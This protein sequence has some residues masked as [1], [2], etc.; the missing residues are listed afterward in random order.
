MAVTI[1]DV[2]KKANVAPSTVSRVIANS[3]RISEKTKKRVRKIMDELGYHPNVNARSLA[4]QT[5]QAIGLIM[6]SS[7]N[8]SFQN[9]F[10]P[11]VMRGISSY[12]H[13]KDYSLY[14]NTGETE[15]EIFEGVVKMV[16]GKRVDGIVVLYSRMNDLVIQ[17]LTE[18]QFPFVLIGKPHH[19][20]EEITYID[21]DNYMAG[22]EVTEY[23]ISLGHEH[24][25]FIGGSPDLMVTKERLA[26]FKEAIKLADLRLPDEYVFYMDFLR[27][28]GQL[29]VERLMSYE[30]PPTA[31]VVTDDLMAMGVLSTLSEK[32]YHVPDDVSV[33]SFNN[34][35]F[36][37]IACPP[38]TS[39][40]VRIFQL[41]YEAVK[42]L[43]EKIEMPEQSSRNIVVPYKIIKRQSCKQMSES[44]LCP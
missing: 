14:M 35:I 29:A 41:G 11:E 33:V 31:I 32:G 16:Q 44:Q 24:I 13:I 40:D 27:E 4:N 10:F 38:L 17:Y 9:P 20:S 34:V 12:A 28:G 19:A 18:Q 26:G 7:A 3:P 36:S 43:I 23:L 42:S 15:E 2:A 30:Q 39:V 25:A 5:T 8:K 37:E 1:K 6:P 22:R 21:N